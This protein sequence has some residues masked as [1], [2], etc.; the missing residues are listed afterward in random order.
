M[1]FIC[2][3]KLLCC[4]IIKVLQT[5][6]TQRNKSSFA[7][8]VLFQ[9]TENYEEFEGSIDNDRNALEKDEYMITAGK[10]LLSFR[11]IGTLRIAPYC[12]VGDLIK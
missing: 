8:A 7:K 12:R 10:Y 4:C 9:F 1:V 5:D 6:R 3:H 2:A 11:P